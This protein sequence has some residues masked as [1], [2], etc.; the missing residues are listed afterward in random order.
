MWATYMLCWALGVLVLKT[1]TPGALQEQAETFTVLKC[2]LSSDA[3]P[4]VYNL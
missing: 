3:Y 1:V 2:R 4:K